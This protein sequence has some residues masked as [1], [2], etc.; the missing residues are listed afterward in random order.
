MS[1]ITDKIATTYARLLSQKNF[2]L[3]TVSQQ[4]GQ[5]VEII[6]ENYLS[7]SER[8]NQIGD[9]LL[10]KNFNLPL[11][12]L[13]IHT[14]EKKNLIIY[15]GTDFTD[16]K[17]IFSDVQIVL[18]TN[19]VDKRVEESLNFYDQVKTSYPDYE[20]WI[21]GHSLG[22]TIAF[23]IAKHRQPNRTITFNP[24]SAPNK[25]FL[26]M[27][28]DTLF[29]KLWTQTITTYKILGDIVSA[30]SFIGN[31]K[32]FILETADPKKLHGIA[33]FKNLLTFR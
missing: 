13:Y 1:I 33:S 9:W 20:I 25:A 29:H 4:D 28:Q 17:D 6:E 24:G 23:I 16:I 7:P 21:S 19:S 27:M 3:S 5:I 12:N 26:S 30:L 22:G 10:D 2:V 14:K 31:T 18:G 32:T 15:R 11:H 8:K